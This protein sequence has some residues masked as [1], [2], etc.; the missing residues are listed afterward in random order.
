VQRI[1]ATGQDEEVNKAMEGIVLPFAKVLSVN[2][3]SRNEKITSPFVSHAINLF[4]L[5]SAILWHSF[6]VKNSQN[7]C[8]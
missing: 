7:A 3:P 1:F 4:F 6:M 8:K 5:L 2:L